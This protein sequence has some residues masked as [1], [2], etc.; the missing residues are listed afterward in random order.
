MI[1]KLRKKNI[2]N[3]IREMR[4]GDEAGKLD[5]LLRPSEGSL[6]IGGPSGN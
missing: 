1:G 5:L 3:G 4:E 6:R 2:W